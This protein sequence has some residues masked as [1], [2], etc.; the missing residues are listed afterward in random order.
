MGTTTGNPKFFV[1]PRLS[2][3]AIY[4]TSSSPGSSTIVYVAKTIDWLNGVIKDISLTS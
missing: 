4:G 2:K 1:S 3:V